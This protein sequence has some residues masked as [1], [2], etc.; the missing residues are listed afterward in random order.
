M[1]SQG[2]ILYATCRGD[3]RFVEG[4][5]VD[6]PAL[7]DAVAAA[8]P[9]DTVQL[10][11]G[12][13]FTP[14]EIDPDNPS[15]I[16]PKP[17]VLSGVVGTADAPITIRGFGARTAL[18]GEG[19]AEVAEARLPTADQFAFFKLL[20]CE[21]IVFE[22]FDVGACWPSFLF[23]QNSRYV[24]VRRL[25]ATD[26]RYLVFARGEGCHHL[27][28]EDIHWRQDTTGSLWRDIS[29][30]AV[31]REDDLGYYYYNGGLFGAVDISGSVVVR[32][33]TICQA[34]NG[35]RLKANAAKAGR[36]NHN[37]EIYANRF[38]DIRDNPVEPERTAV[39]WHIR[40]N[41]IVNAHAWFSLDAV[42]GG[43]WYF[44]GNKGYFNDRQGQP[45]GD[46][47]GGA[48]Y[49]FDEEGAMPDRY[50]L[51]AG[52]SF[53]LR[54]N[55]IKEGR[56]RHFHHVGNVVLFCT[57]RDL[58]GYDPDPSCPFPE[59]CPDPCAPQPPTADVETFGCTAPDA[60]GRSF[61]AAPNFLAD[62]VGD[63]LRFDGDLTNRP[64]PE[65]FGP[66]GFETGGRRDPNL[67]FRAPFDG[68]L[69]LAGDPLP[70]ASLT[71]RA[72][73]DW[74]GD[75]DWQPPRGAVA[76]ALQPHALEHPWEAAPVAPPFVFCPP[77]DPA[78]GYGEGPRPVA[79]AWERDSLVVHFSRP[80]AAGPV[81]AAVED[82]QGR[83]QAVSGRADGTRLFLDVP[84]D[85]RR[86]VTAVAVPAALAGAD[87]EK[88]SFFA[89]DERVKIL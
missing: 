81:T 3:R 86:R 51:A 46:N 53:F 6:A 49:K 32:R 30:E 35:L 89:A 77:A 74:P 83:R 42:G 75:Y 15:N 8:G 47:T 40:A 29:W 13:Y 52:N 4:V 5:P 38:H 44:C 34:F 85:Y 68:D 82:R 50:A 80:L 39:N 28:L 57:P 21:W 16:V 9:G 22:D 12:A 17:I 56:T 1:S 37:V 71:L 2:R 27:L 54:S 66:A 20:N 24:T 76:G 72:G 63:D 43:F 78:P 23:I 73:L 18:R 48:V 25:T 61:V 45:E 88:V 31:K 84:G 11:P 64:F 67:R 87:G 33:N 59:S 65:A 55:L 7:T 26:G 14:T 58:A 60:P 36:L 10:L 62:P 70:F 41:V 79:L 19:K 69:R